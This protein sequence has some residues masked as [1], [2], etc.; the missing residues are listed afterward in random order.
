VIVVV[1]FGVSLVASLAFVYASMYNYSGGWALYEFN[2]LAENGST[3]HIDNL[4][5]T[6]GV[7]R[8]G[9]MPERLIVYDKTEA[10]TEEGIQKR[11][12]DYL[13]HESIIPGFKLLKTIRGFQGF[14]LKVF[15][16]RVKLASQLYVLKRIQ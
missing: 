12:Y 16:P 10:L 11:E 4:A 14:N 5:A 9:E 7:S 1:T 2:K 13:I 8:F 3:V 6:T 15:L